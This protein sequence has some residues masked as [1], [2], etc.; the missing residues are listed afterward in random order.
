VTAGTGLDGGG[1][2]GSVT[3]SIA[4]GGV[5]QTAAECQNWNEFRSQ[6][7]PE[8]YTCVQI[9]STAGKDLTSCG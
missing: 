8:N 5:T 6:L 4:A 9:S 1:T 2:S 7:V 3:L